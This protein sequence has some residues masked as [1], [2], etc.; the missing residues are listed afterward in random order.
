MEACHHPPLHQVDNCIPVHVFPCKV[1]IIGSPN[2]GYL[3]SWDLKQL[4][5]G[6]SECVI[7]S[8]SSCLGSYV[9][10][11]AEAHMMYSNELS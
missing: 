9:G 11:H 10:H 8:K 6:G 5:D 4:G 2:G 7:Y 3:L 1:E